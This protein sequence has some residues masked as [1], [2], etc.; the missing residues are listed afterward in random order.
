MQ[1]LQA[2]Q[3]LEYLIDLLIF[4]LN[5]LTDIDGNEFACGEQS[6][7]IECLEIIQRWEY[8]EEYGLN[9]DIEEK[10]PLIEKSLGQMLS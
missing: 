2:E 7:Y 3:V 4:Y 10:F 5:E 8:A 6:A 9:F 1:Q